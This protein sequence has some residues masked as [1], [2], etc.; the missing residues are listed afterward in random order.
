[1]VSSRKTET[2][3]H[4]QMKEK[5]GDLYNLNNNNR[6]PINKSKLSLRGEKRKLCTVSIQFFI[7]LRAYSTAQRPTTT[8]IIRLQMFNSVVMYHSGFS[9]A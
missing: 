7:Y 3:I 6:S 4:K 9:R 8:I 1:M 5:Q 2:H